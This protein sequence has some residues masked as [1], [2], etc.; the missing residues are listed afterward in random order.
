MILGMTLFWEV[1]VLSYMGL[2]A[3]LSYVRHQ[4]MVPIW[5]LPSL[6]GVGA[7]VFHITQAIAMSSRFA[8]LRP[9]A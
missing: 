5:F 7:V 6:V 4:A 9:L 3:D 2:W 1:I 8:S